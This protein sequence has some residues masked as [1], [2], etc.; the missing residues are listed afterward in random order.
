VIDE[1]VSEYSEEASASRNLLKR[2]ESEV[3][4]PSV[5]LNNLVPARVKQEKEIRKVHGP[6]VLTYCY[7]KF[8]ATVFTICTPPAL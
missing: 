2:V 5:E 3:V 8:Q 6:W 4:T 1:A 7:S